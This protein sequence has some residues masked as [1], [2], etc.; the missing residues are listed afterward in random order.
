MLRKLLLSEEPD[1]QYAK[2][3]DLKDCCMMAADSW[4]LVKSSTLKK[5]WNNILNKEKTDNGSAKS[6]NENEE[7]KTMKE[8]GRILSY[9][10]NEINKWLNN[11]ADYPGYQ[12]LN[13]DEIVDEKEI[14]ENENE[15][16]ENDQ[17]P[18]QKKAF[19]CLETAM[20][21]LER[22]E[23]AD[24]IQPVANPGEGLSGC[25]LPLELNQNS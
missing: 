10:E 14:E 24:P 13:D 11:D 5:S 7:C 16:S 21:G 25:S 2:K 15:C 22:Q 17:G 12:I 20:K 19:E 4:N 23:N 18:S 1:F 9:E 8:M 3:V 6:G